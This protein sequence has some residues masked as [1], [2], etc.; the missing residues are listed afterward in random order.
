MFSHKVL[1]RICLIF[2][3]PSLA[4]FMKVL[5]ITKAFTIKNF[6]ER[7]VFD[8]KPSENFTIRKIQCQVKDKFE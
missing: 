4:L 3:N 8:N 1:L 7:N 6:Y 2:I 5:L